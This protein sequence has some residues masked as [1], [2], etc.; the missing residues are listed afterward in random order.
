MASWKNSIVIHAPVDRVFAFVDDPR[1]LTEWLPGMVDVHNVDGTAEGQQH[2]WTYEMAGVPL[3]GQAV[4]VEHVP[5]SRA[6]HQSIGMVHA[7][8]AYSVEAH[9]EGT[10]LTFEIEYTVPVPVLGRLAE[11]TVI[12]RNTRAFELALENVKE[13]LET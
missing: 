12:A 4:V 3:R 13:A 6:V 7:T 9:A 5:S 8:F 2:E 1:T 10:R 11:Q